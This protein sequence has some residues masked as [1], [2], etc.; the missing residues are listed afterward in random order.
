VGRLVQANPR[1]L[2][3]R[4][5]VNALLVTLVL[6]LLPAIDVELRA[7]LAAILLAALLY[8]V[9]DALIRPLLN[10]LLMPFVV[11]SYGMALV[12]V[13]IILFGLLL[14][15]L[16]PLLELLDSPLSIDR[17]LSILVGGLLLGVLRLAA[18]AL[19]GLTPPVAVEP[20]PTPRPHKSA[21]LGSGF[22]ERLRL[23][24]VYQT[25]WVSS[26]DTIM[27]RDSAIA[28]NRWRMQQWLWHPPVPPGHVPA[29]VRFRLTLQELGPTYVKVGQIISSQGRA[30][31]AEWFIELEK[32]QSDV[33]PF[34]Y[35]Q[36]REQIIGALGAP[37][38]ELYAHFDETP[39][40]AAS[41]AQVH[42]ATLQDGRQVV[43]KVQRPGI[44]AQLRFDVRILVRLGRT[45][46]RRTRWAEDVGLSGLLLEFG[47]TLL[48]ELDYTIEAY[49]ARRLNRV[50]A[51][52]EGMHVPEAFDELSSSQ[53][54]TLEFIDGVKPTR[55]AE[56]DAAGIDREIL[57]E[58]MIRGAVKMMLI[59]GF[60]HGDP[61]PGNVLV[62][63][64]TGRLTLLDTGMVG[65]L[66]IQQR[67]KMGSL[68]L[69][70]RNRD[71]RGL[72]QTLKSLSTPF[73]ETDDAKYYKDFERKLTPYLDPPPG[74]SVEVVSKVLPAAMD[75]LREAGYRLDPQL[76]L[77]I[78]AMTQAE[79]ITAALVPAWT[80]SQFMERAVEATLE[81]LPDVVTP[82]AMKAAAV[83]QTSYVVR[84]AAQQMPAL[85]EGLLK[86]LGIV[87]SG[88][89][90]VELDTS[91]LDVQMQKLR[92][93]AMLVTLGILIVGLVIGSAIA[94][95]VGGVE[96]SPL[97]PL[98]DFSLLIFAGSS[99]IGAVAVVA[100]TIRIVRRE[101]RKRGP[102]D[103]I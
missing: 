28:R 43:V 16:A 44:H 26:I 72:A 32:L 101:P 60:F 83:K 97:A 99:L 49:N 50:L 47:T 90:K 29:P 48:R 9:L 40:A 59:D 7:P 103:S 46:E 70:I 78:K 89:L 5:A 67:V 33:G 45:L 51:A 69:V 95:G 17:P 100:L 93:I 94:A 85:Q 31:P 81:M 73:R 23:L 77:A 36:V 21:R 56:I 91:G 4:I 75:T 57:G 38:E 52:I 71:V 76:T 98:Q 3:V 35:E 34:P 24:H 39:L 20:A 54:L 11:Q 79:A 15:I 68:L 88:G 61:H 62:E 18:E 22:S 86:W 80:G 41:L 65:E 58:R 82:E 30:L 19:L 42:R 13:D 37:P 8:S 25:L 66:T 92:G 12:A 84:E 63:L 27:D 1:V 10:L 102:L 74:R 64:D 96:D 6:A 55:A 2:L 53:V 14:R 87:K